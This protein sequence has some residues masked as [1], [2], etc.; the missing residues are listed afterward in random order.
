[1]KRLLAMLAAPWR[2]MRLKRRVVAQ[3]GTI[4]A[5]RRE[6]LWLRAELTN[7]RRTQR[8]A[9]ILAVRHHR[10]KLRAQEV[11]AARIEAL[12]QE[13]DILADRVRELQQ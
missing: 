11:V 2:V 13:N 8:D 12:Q 10:N 6:I 5:Q 7:L 9:D 1:M 4:I 3:R